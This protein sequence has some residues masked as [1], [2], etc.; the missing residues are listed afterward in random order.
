MLMWRHIDDKDVITYSTY[1]IYSA[2]ASVYQGM[3]AALWSKKG[4]E[5]LQCGY[6]SVSMNL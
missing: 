5:L 2:P 1:K 6:Q 3:V 4:D